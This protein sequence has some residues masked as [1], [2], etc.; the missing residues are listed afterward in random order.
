MRWNWSICRGA[1][2]AYGE[3][4]GFAVGMAF[5]GLGG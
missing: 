5:G 3:N 2:N 4:L 1:A